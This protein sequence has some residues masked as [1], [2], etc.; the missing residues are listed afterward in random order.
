MGFNI[1]GYPLTKTHEA[2][3]S[4][5]G[6][7]D[8]GSL[9]KVQDE[10]GK[11]II[12]NGS[13]WFSD[14]DSLQPGKGYYVNV[15]QN[16]S[17]NF[18]SLKSGKISTANE[19][20]K[21]TAYFQKSFSGNPYL[22]MVFLVR[23]LAKSNLKLNAGDEIG[24]FDGTACVGSGVFDGTNSFG[25]SAGMA[26]PI[27]HTNGFN[28]GDT[29][30]FQVW[31]PTEQILIKNI[32]IIY[33]NNSPY[34]FA[35]LE[36]AIIEL[37]AQLVNVVPMITSEILEVK[38]YPNPFTSSTTFEFTVNET[39]N[40]TLEIFDLLGKKVTELVNQKY[41]SGSYSIVWNGINA[42]GQFINPGIYVYC[43]RAGNFVSSKKLIFSGQ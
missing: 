29:I 7:T 34:V 30:H 11:F 3:S 38:N 15:S 42:N 25:L 22:A 19:M 32:T 14:I 10:T 8:E 31:K 6:L 37:Q 36:T 41:V 16:S 43:F 12:K 5:Q 9:I 24:I 17:M 40:V 33:L 13:T 18:G 20:L 39:S 27:S 1:I 4:F 35:P 28:Y 2:L 26:D 21:S 23:N